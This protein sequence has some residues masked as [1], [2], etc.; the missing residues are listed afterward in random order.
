M[1]L[2]VC[3]DSAPVILAPLTTE[4]A[5]LRAVLYADT[6]DYPL[7]PREIHRY[8]IGEVA[9]LDDLRAILESSVWLKGRLANVGQAYAL[10]RRAE[11]AALRRRRV[12]HARRLWMSARRYGRIIAHLPFVRMVAVTGAL[13]MDNAAAGDDV[14][15]LLV[16]APGRVW[17][18]RAFAIVVARLAGARLCPN[19]LLAE[20]SLHL[21]RRDLFV[22]HEL[23]QMVPLAGFERY[24]AMLQAN[25][26]AGRFLP[27]AALPPRREPDGA[28]RG[29]GKRAQRLAE[30]LLSG[31]LGNA[32]ENWER[33]RKLAKFTPQLRQ[34]GSAAAPHCESTNGVA[35]SSFDKGHALRLAIVSPY[36]PQISGIGQYGLT[37]PEWREE[38]VN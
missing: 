21:E 19:Y 22:A 20:T 15:Y 38:C 28:P 33:R 37:D 17:L 29:L 5:I 32:L 36:P 4:A 18:A 10:T 8:L 16:T 34:A 35:R 1:T 11:L 9:S 31:K 30:W 13:A 7:T 6:F 27:N 24:A 26:W 25:A 23:A 14:D 3:A 2:L 12:E